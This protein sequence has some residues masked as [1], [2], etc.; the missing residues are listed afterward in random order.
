MIAGS[1][2]LFLAMHYHVVHGDD[3]IVLVPKISHS[4]SDMYVDTRDLELSDWK[5]HKPLAA[6]IIRSRQSHLLADSSLS[7]FRDSMQGL[8]EG[9][10]DN[11]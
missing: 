10:F 4:L 8:V 2:L 9:L 5:N 7:E 3:G 1:V 11:R 6:A